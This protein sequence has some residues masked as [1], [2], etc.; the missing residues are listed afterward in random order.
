VDERV[1]RDLYLCNILELG[2]N[3]FGQVIKENEAERDRLEGRID[4][5]Y[6]RREEVH[7]RMAELA[8]KIKKSE[9]G[10]LY[11][12]N[13]ESE[14]E[15]L[16]FSKRESEDTKGKLSFAYL[17]DEYHDKRIDALSQ[18]ASELKLMEERARDRLNPLYAD[19]KCLNEQY[20]QADQ[21]T[22]VL[23]ALSR[24]K[25]AEITELHRNKAR[26][27]TELIRIMKEQMESA[28]LAEKSA[29]TVNSNLAMAGAAKEYIARNFYPIFNRMSLKIEPNKR[30]ESA[31]ARLASQ[32]DDYC[33][34]AQVGS[35]DDR[36]GAMA[37][38]YE[39]GII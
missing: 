27:N 14:I 11:I 25:S 9:N 20:K 24:Q 35:E 10:I 38:L 16:V 6:A 18:E 39:R 28:R 32:L 17:S 22:E 1:T 36:T 3:A 5:A 12:A 37:I 33:E 29:R 30:G 4:E 13:K 31:D 2:S 19:V 8:G 34:R 15:R 23:R 26:I 7:S 21:N